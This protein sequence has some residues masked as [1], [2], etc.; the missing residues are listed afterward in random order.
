MP[1]ETKREGNT[2]DKC[3]KPNTEVGAITYYT[4]P[5][6]GYEGLLCSECIKKREKSYTEIC[7]KCKRL[8]YKHGGMSFYGEPP[9]DDEEMCL[10]CVE[11]TERK[12]AKR[13]AI[14]LKIKNFTKDNWRFW[15]MVIIG[16]LGLIGLSRFWPSN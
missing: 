11:K 14:K 6:D 2:C 9:Y 15:I 3:H 13:I 7:P 8:A 4:D 16:I 12:M 10:E 5:N 1:I